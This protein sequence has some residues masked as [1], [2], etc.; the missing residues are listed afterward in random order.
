MPR[1]FGHG[2]GYKPDQ[3]D[4]RDLKV[5]ALGL[6]TMGLPRAVS[7]EH[8]VTNV[9]NQGPTS[10]CVAQALAAAIDIREAGAGLRVDPVSRLFIYGNSRLLDDPTHPRRAVLSDGGTYIRNACK[11][12][13]RLGAPPESAWPWS[14]NPI[15]VRRQPSI[16]SYMAAHKRRVVGAGYYRIDD[17]GTSRILALQAA[18]ASGRPVVFGTNVNRAFQSNDGPRTID[19]PEPLDPIA[20]G[21]AM[22]LVGYD[23]LRTGA[24][25]FWVLNSW[26]ERWR[27]GGFAW[28]TAAYMSHPST[29]D[30][31][32]VEAWP[33]LGGAHA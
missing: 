3:E 9:R 32:I 27:S 30:I 25:L 20:G 23:T 4:A 2:L 13:Q 28:L 29:R 22:C 33:A 1:L 14:T 7:L 17:V 21:H 26:G 18:L 10:S 16:A 31:W 12:L 15:K 5:S 19:A 6:S 24:V 11:A 8:L